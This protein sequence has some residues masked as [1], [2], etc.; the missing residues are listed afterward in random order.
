MCGRFTLTSSEDAIQERFYPMFRA[1]LYKP[2][3]NVAPT[4]SVLTVVNREEQQQPEYMRWGLIPSWAKDPK[5]G[6]RMINAR[7]ETVGETSAFRTAFAKRRCLIVAD[8][9]Y[10]W[11][12]EGKQRTPMLFRLKDGEPFA[13]A[14]IWE[15][16]KDPNNEWLLSCSIITTGPNELTIPVHDRMPVILHPEAEEEWLD[17]DA[18]VATLRSL[19]NPYDSGRMEA[20]AVSPVVNSPKNDTPECVVPGLAG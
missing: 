9:F 10:E 3:Y 12:K 11:K 2:R 20:Y 13:F 4:Q 17:P 15:V 16:W 7:A 5:I 18:E 19:L 14:G 8:G 6:Y 1:S